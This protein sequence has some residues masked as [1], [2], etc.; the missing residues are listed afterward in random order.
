MPAASLPAT[1]NIFENFEAL[2]SL[3]ISESLSALN[4]VAERAR[5]CATFLFGLAAIV[6]SSP[7][8]PFIHSMTLNGDFYQSIEG[9]CIFNRKLSKIVS[10]DPK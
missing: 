2:Q 6:I 9:L 4:S 1:G 8:R 10:R 5:I 7:F 3:A